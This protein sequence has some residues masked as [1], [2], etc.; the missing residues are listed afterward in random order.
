MRVV[1]DRLPAG[2]ARSALRA[3][4]RAPTEGRMLVAGAGL[5]VALGFVISLLLSRRTALWL[6][7]AQTVDIARLP[8][9]DLLN[10]LR[11]DGSPPLYYLLLHGWM[12]LFGT[13]DVAVRSLSTLL[14]VG[15]V[16]LV[17]AAGRR[18]GGSRVAAASALLLGSLPFLH[19]YAT[20]ARMYSLVVLLSVAGFVLLRRAVD[21]PS[22]AVLVGL[23]AVTGLLLLTHYWTFFLLTAVAAVFS[24]ALLR[25]HPDGP[26]AAAYGRVLAAMAVGCVAFLPWA[27]SFLYQLRHTGA[28][29]GM[30]AGPWIFESS[31]RA[32][33]G[34]RGTLGLL[35][36]LYVFLAAL[37]LWARPMASGRLELD[38]AGRPVARPL[39]IVVVATLGLAMV[40]SQLTD[41]AFA[42]R[43]AAVVVVPFVLLAGRGLSVVEHRRALPLVV[44]ALVGLGLFQSFEAAGARRTQAPRIAGVLR[45]AAGPDDIVA[46]CPDQLAPAVVRLLEPSSMSIVTFPPGSPGRRVN[47]VDYMAR[48]DST[49]AAAFASMLDNR[50][51]GATVWFAW[52]P[53]YRGVVPACK[54]VISRLR[55]IRPDFKRAVAEDYTAYEH[56]SLWRFPPPDNR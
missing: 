41:S 45:A 23:A 49:T 52:S 3:G 38:L 36:F 24:V 4:R 39:I 25:R 6:D 1:T 10:A 14:A 9:G 34:D 16:G 11:T 15:A 19:R 18:F 27:P 13:G 12:K 37:G 20:E 2:P 22:V 44:A 31:L 30:T 46:F 8:L 40:V 5:V 17:P 48:A 35:G 43:Y 47:W 50:A 42:P 55:R 32:L 21:E 33:A 26:P 56:A 29:W 54:D 53:N 51:E 7:E 28:P